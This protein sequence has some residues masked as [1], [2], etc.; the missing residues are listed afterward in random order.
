SVHAERAE[1]LDPLGHRLGADVELA[2]CGRFVKSLI[3]H[4][5]DH[6]LSTFRG[7]R[8]ILVRVHSVPRESLVVWRL[9]RSRSGPNGQPPASSHLAH[10]T[11][12]YASPS[13]RNRLPAGSPP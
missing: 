7:Q 4:G 10:P 5:S 11:P 12:P 9:Q 8:G 6:V 2:C 13:P 1:P 3:K